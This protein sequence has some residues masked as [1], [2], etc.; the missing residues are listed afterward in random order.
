M[1]LITVEF[2]LH[3]M[4][5]GLL[6]CNEPFRNERFVRYYHNLNVGTGALKIATIAYMY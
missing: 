3:D 2:I 4:S 6:R 1:Y 5:T